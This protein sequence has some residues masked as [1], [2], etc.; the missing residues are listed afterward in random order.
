MYDPRFQSTRRWMGT[1]TLQLFSVEYD[2]TEERSVLRGA[3][4]PNLSKSRLDGKHRN[5]STTGHLSSW[6]P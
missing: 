1:P 6:A 2:R 5:A 4:R 3:R